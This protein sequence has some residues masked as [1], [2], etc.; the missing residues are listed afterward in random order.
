MAMT[1]SCGKYFVVSSKDVNILV[2]NRFE[3]LFASPGVISLSWIKIGIFNVFAAII[4]GTDTKPPFE[5]RV[6]PVLIVSKFFLLQNSLLGREKHPLRFPY[7]NNVV[8]FHY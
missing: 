3:I 6:D 2:A 4:T 1:L 8:I 5:K 7:L